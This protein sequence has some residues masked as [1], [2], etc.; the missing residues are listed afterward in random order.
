[1]SMTTM[2]M[3]MSVEIL[4]LGRSILEMG[5][6]LQFYMVLFTFVKQ[7]FSCACMADSFITVKILLDLNL[8]LYKEM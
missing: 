3:T 4:R 5:I 7:F 1:M 2:T 8:L 6:L